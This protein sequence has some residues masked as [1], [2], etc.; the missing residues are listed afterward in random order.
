MLVA[1]HVKF[2]HDIVWPVNDRHHGISA[3][4]GPLSQAYSDNEIKAHSNT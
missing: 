2:H 1:L 3:G 4:Y